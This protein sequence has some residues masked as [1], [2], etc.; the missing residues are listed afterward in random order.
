MR[1]ILTEEG[2]MGMPKTEKKAR[3]T[4]EMEILHRRY[5]GDNGER[6]TSL[7]REMFE[8]FHPKM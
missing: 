1:Y 6:R 8:I 5:V 7:Q 4:S 2:K 3:R